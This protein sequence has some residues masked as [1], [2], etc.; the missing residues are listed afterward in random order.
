MGA[1]S[2]RNA[3]SCPAEQKNYNLTT[4]ATTSLMHLSALDEG[5]WDDPRRRS[6]ASFPGRDEAKIE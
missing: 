4:G 3:I 1:Q 5:A 6:A 2:P